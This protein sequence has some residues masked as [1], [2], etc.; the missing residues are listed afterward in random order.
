[1]D[2][3]FTYSIKNILQRHIG[4]HADDI[5]EKSQLIQ[6]IN[7]KTRSANRGSKSR[8]SFANIYAIYVLIEDYILNG[9]DKNNKYSQYEGA[10]FNK[11][12]SRQRELPFG[13]KLQN[14][15]LNN[16][17]NSEFQKYWFSELSRGRYNFLFVI[18][19]SATLHN[20]L[21]SLL[22]F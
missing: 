17:V 2:N 21:K 12:L 5:F 4:K 18:W 6:Y 14:H 19:A 20:Y 10:L 22:I 3:I 7:M 13:S 1:M 8:S 11:L 15:A 16:R 9:Y